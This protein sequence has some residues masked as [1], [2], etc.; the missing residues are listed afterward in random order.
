[1]PLKRLLAM[2]IKVSVIVPVYNVE[3]YVGK[4]IDSILSQTYKNYELILLN[5]GSTDGSYD[6]LLKYEG[7][8]CVT[9]VNKANTGQS[10]TRYQGL[11]MA[12]GDYVYFVDSDDF[13]ESDT[14]EK[15]IAQA[16]ETNADVVFGR[17]R[18]IDERGNILREQKKYTISSLIGTE[19]ILRD[20]I[21]VSN[22]KASLCIKLIKRNHLVKSYVEEIR[23][24]HLNEDI[25]LSI[26]LALHCRRVSFINDII[27]NVLQ[28][29]DSLTRNLKPELITENE[30]IFYYLNL[31]IK[32]RGLWELCNKEYYNGY[33]KTIVYALSITAVRCSSFFQ[34]LSFYQLLEKESLFYSAELE[35]NKSILTAINKFMFIISRYPRVFYIIIQGF[36]PVLRY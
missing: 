16:D 20:A 27:Y 30:K 22:F 12:K 18:L 29:G 28:R 31:Y 35:S 33:V 5:D 23:D 11:L 17:Y 6:V 19:N 24:I 8:P 36:K 21:C 2:S 34:F 14:L 3:A 26:I 7:N 25:F 15:L 1:M 32:N 10:D 13:I 9:I 4:C